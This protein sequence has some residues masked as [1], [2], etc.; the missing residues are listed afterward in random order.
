MRA[1]LLDMDD[2][3]FDH[4]LSCREAIRL[5]RLETAFLRRRRL[6][7]LWQEY[8]RLLD[9]L[10]VTGTGRFATGRSTREERWRR[11]AVSCGAEL[12][13]EEVRQLSD[14]YR[15]LYLRVR[16]PVPGAVPLVRRLHRAA[17]VA[18]VTNNEVAEQEEKL[19]FLGLEREVDALVVSQEVGLTKPD[20]GIFEEA[21]RRVDCAAEEA[22]MVGDSWANDIVGARGV[23]IRPV[24][25]N[26]FRLP[27][28]DGAAAEELRSFRPARSAEELLLGPRVEGLSSRQ[29]RA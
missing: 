9:T 5:V 10:I 20:P 6:D 2:T 19:R 12:T 15:A 27:Q 26:R 22:V 8:S 21:L 28:P 25:F 13:P 18:I 3:I 14:R 1:V 16:R 11:L 17:R 23:G 4:A 24:W 29:A 7:E